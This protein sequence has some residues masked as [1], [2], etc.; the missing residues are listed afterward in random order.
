MLTVSGP[1]WLPQTQQV[2]LTGNAVVNANLTPSSA[3]VT[4]VIGVVG[5]GGLSD[6]GV[7]LSNDTQTFKTLTQSN[8]PVGSYTFGQVPP[9]LYVLSAES[10]GYTTESSEV[11]VGPG[12]TQTINL[13]LPYVGQASEATG[14]IQ[15]T[16][17][18]LFSATPIPTAMVY[19]DGSATGYPAGT[20]AGYTIPDVTP[21]IHTITAKAPGHQNASVSVT[22]PLGAIAFAPPI[23]L[24]T[25]DT[26]YG[27]VS[28]ALGGPV[29][30]PNVTLLPA[31]GSGT[32]P[33]VTYGPP[34]LVP[35]VPPPAQG[36]FEVDNIPQGNYLLEVAG[37]ATGP[38]PY[39]T[40]FVPVTLGLGAAP[41]LQN[42]TL[43]LSPSFTVTTYLTS[44]TSSP[45]A[46]PG[47]TVQLCLQ[48]SPASCVALPPADTVQ[49]DANGVAFVGG[50][51]GGLTYT[52]SFSYTDGNGQSW[53]A[54]PVSFLAAVN[55][56][57]YSAY[58]TPVLS[59]Q[60]TV[61]LNYL[62]GGAA[63]PILPPGSSGSGSCPGVAAGFVPPTISLTGNFYG[64]PSPG[65]GSTTQATVPASGPDV[66]GTYTFAP[67]SLSG[68]TPAAVSYNVNGTSPTFETPPIPAKT[69]LPSGPTSITLTP[70]PYPLAATSYQGPPT[71][72]SPGRR[73]AWR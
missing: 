42:V 53:Q 52:A 26:I 38:N 51:Q 69:A 41:F 5:G 23:L 8:A 43:N 58:L 39:V 24:P 45:S 60:P 40:A 14:T 11:A 20:S 55:P 22:V 50:L 62:F 36:G 2:Q 10:F 54:L 30:D 27:T 73:S 63:C 68:L 37:P 13:N 15:G 6:V 65:Q 18:D 19:L 72:R 35:G 1:G 33:G 29:P 56:Q 31:S 12:Q 71:F 3:N 16:V 70:V 46:Q 57:P 21:G 66:T 25:L 59:G 49:S 64:A 47:V 61:S 48:V 67:G 4:G 34:F 17:V 7:V 44:S 32:V 28:S 9:G